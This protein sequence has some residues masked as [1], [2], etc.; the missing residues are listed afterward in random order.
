MS[1]KEKAKYE[2][3]Q[4]ADQERYNDQ[5]SQLK[6]KG[7]FMTEDGVKSTDLPQKENKAK[8]VVKK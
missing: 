2:K 5:I 7:F 3:L 8:K 4:A 1:P 6:K